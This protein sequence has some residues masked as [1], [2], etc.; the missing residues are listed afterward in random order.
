MGVQPLEGEP[1]GEGYLPAASS[2]EPPELGAPSPGGG[3]GGGGGLLPSSNLVLPT[4]SPLTVDITNSLTAD[5]HQRSLEHT[6]ISSNNTSPELEGIYSQIIFFLWLNSAQ[7]VR[8]D[9]DKLHAFRHKCLV[10]P[11]TQLVP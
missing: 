8:S 7:D 1:G 5:N 11:L 2:S 6:S 4:R 3:S 10:E 9:Q